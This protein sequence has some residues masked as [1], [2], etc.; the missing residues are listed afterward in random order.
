MLEFSKL[1]HTFYSQETDN[2]IKKSKFVQMHVKKRD[3]AANSSLPLVSEAPIDLSKKRNP[4]TEPRVDLT[5]EDIQS[6]HRFDKACCC[7]Q[8][9]Q[10]QL[11][12]ICD[13]M[14]LT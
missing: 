8:T 10:T 12:V 1:S 9:I 2:L 13:A 6:V 4:L 5:G 11:V 7:T 14:K 3:A